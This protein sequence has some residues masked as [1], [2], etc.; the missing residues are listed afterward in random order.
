M[1]LLVARVAKNAG[2]LL[3]TQVITWT[4]SIVV[5]IFLS[6]YLGPVGIGKLNLAYSLWAIIVIFAG[7]GLESLLIKEI[8]RSPNLINELLPASAVLRSFFFT[9]GTIVVIAYAFL[10]GYP[11]ETIHVI[12]IVGVNYLIVQYINTVETAFRGI[13]RMEFISFSLIISKVLYGIGAITVVVLGYGVLAVAAVS[14]FASIID[15]S[16]MVFFLKKVRGLGFHFEF[17]WVRWALKGGLPFLFVSLFIVLYH[18]IDVI[19]LSVLVSE[20][21]VGWYGVADQVTGNL[22]FVPTVFMGAVFPALSRLY[23]GSQDS[24]QVLFRKSFNLLMILGVPIGLGIALI[25]PSIV[26]L[27]F[28]DQYGPSGLI[29][30]V[31]GLVLILTYQTMLV[32]LYFISSDRQIIWTWVMAAACAVT[33]PLDF[34]LI[35]YFERTLGNGAL[36]GAVSYLVTE[37]GMIAFGV[38][39][40]R[41]EVF[42]RESLTH[43]LRVVAA[44]AGMVAATWHF[45]EMMVALPIAVGAASYTGLIL[46]FK[47]LH[48]EDWA[49]IHTL[50]QKFAARLA[51]RRV[52]P[53]NVK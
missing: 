1:Q 17:K 10:V 49:L 42:N 33:I 25:A 39:W 26:F 51:S 18:Q 8:A 45:R 48:P 16:L 27:M 13:E 34:A 9:L 5:M 46:L 28:G 47:V 50:Y 22:L 20:Q 14:I 38:Y 4:L 21:S 30:T 31:R 41:R 2:I 29:L 24:M 7:Y 35:P 6:R 19:L 36:G 32:G 44:G 53:A 23:V 12:L 11:V 43:T 40:L 37:A 52:Q 15:L 3:S